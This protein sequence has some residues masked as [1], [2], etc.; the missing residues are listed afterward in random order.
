LFWCILDADRDKSTIIQEAKESEL[1][2]D[3]DDAVTVIDVVMEEL[4]GNSGMDVST[5]Y[6]CTSGT[7]PD[8]GVEETLPEEQTVNFSGGSS[9]HYQRFQR[10]SSEPSEE[11]TVLVEEDDDV[12]ILSVTKRK[13]PPVPTIGTAFVCGFCDTAFNLKRR[14]C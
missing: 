11:K 10:Y 5:K 8:S 9:A 6:K 1:M 14:K 12:V 13:P 7:S 3:G 2:E 4:D